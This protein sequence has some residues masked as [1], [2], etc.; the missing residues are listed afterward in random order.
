MRAHSFYFYHVRFL[1]QRNSRLTL[2]NVRLSIKLTAHKNFIHFNS[3]P[4]MRL[5]KIYLRYHPPGIALSYKVK[6]EEKLKH[7]D[8]LHLTLK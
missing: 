2:D 4:N 5:I 3:I 8:L 7:I 6:S 1:V